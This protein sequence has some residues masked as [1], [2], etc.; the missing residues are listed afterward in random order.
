M[1]T[2]MPRIAIAAHN[3]EAMITTFRDSLGMPVI[4]IS[5]SSVDSLGAKLAM[6]VPEGGSN[7]ELMSPADPDA[8]LSQS[9]QRFLDR[10]GEGLF[11]LMLEAPVPDDE[12][13]ILL[14]RG[15]NILPLMAGAGGRDIHPKSTHGV[16]I[17]VYPVNS[18]S[19]EM[20]SHDNAL[21][22]SG[23]ARV[24]V[25]V[26]DLDAAVAVYGGQIGLPVDAP[27]MGANYALTTALCRPATGGVIELMACTDEGA[28]GIP[29]GGTSNDRA[30]SVSEHLVSQG[31]GMYALVLQTP[32]I[33]RAAAILLDRGLEIVEA[34]DALEAILFGARIRIEASST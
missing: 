3:F 29:S 16:L 23:I 30:V 33:E 2:G 5:A 21:P 8:P 7:I 11:A 4:D 14:G 31:E 10:R 6:C 1:I 24:I 20:A 15:L 12:A 9:L 22:M 17:R 19:G 26:D 32:D 28:E 13:E 18:F 25:V 34:H 27:R